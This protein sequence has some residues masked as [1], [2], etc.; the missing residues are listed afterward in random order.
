MDLILVDTPGRSHLNKNEVKNIE[1]FL[2]AAQPADTHLL[3]SA[4]T[5]DNDAYTIVETFAPE[6][7][8]K[9]I[10]TKLDETLSFG[11]IL[12]ISVK[13]KKPI[14]YLTTGQN[15]PD[16]IRLADIDF[17]VDLFVTKNRVKTF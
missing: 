14:S 2:E 3:I 11:S 6:Y 10:F 5:K 16:D 7:V 17:L 15:V 13:L 8:Q 1:E 9:L 12:N 4:S